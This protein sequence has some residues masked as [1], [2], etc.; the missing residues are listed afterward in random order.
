MADGK[1]QMAEKST[2][3]KV[4]STKTKKPKPRK[5]C[6]AEFTKHPLMQSCRVTKWQSKKKVTSN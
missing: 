2:K 3:T 5:S 4:Q 1:W 6:H